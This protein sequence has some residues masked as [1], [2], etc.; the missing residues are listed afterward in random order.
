MGT[1]VNRSKHEG[2]LNQECPNLFLFA[3]ACVRARVRANGHNRDC[4][5][6]QG[7]HVYIKIMVRIRNS[8]AGREL[9]TLD[10]NCTCKFSY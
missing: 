2:H 5:L 1:C 7:S 10:L 4:G 8:V 6:V 3:R 9:E